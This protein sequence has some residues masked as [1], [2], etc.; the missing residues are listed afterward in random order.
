MLDKLLFNLQI[1]CF[2]WLTGFFSLLAAEDFGSVNVHIATTRT[3]RNGI[4][5]LEDLSECL[6][7]LGDNLMHFNWRALIQNT[8]VDRLFLLIP[9]LLVVPFL[10]NTQ[11]IK[12]PALRLLPFL[13]HLTKYFQFIPRIYIIFIAKSCIL[14]IHL[15]LRI[16]NKLLLEI[17]VI[18]Y[19]KFL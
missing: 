5:V 7:T 13:L 11:P 6:I 3:K 15:Q 9:I 16:L 14:S 1:E 12:Y 8:H 17:S 2:F 4:A 18:I 10:V 19:I